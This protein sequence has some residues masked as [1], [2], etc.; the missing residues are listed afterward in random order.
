MFLRRHLEQAVPVLSE[1]LD[2]MRRP[3]IGQQQL[4]GFANSLCQDADLAGVLA[5]AFDVLGA[6]GRLEIRAGRSRKLVL[7]LFDGVYWDGGL[8][9]H[10]LAGY[11]SSKISLTDPAF[12]VTD[13]EIKEPEELLPLLD[14]A[15]GAGIATLC[16][17]PPAYPTRRYRSYCC[18]PIAST[19]RWCR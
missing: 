12:L 13:L 14:L 17:W 19:S 10:T 3:L 7:E 16:C 5:E 8:L 9:N 11:A 4:A 1:A 18:R 2:G 15:C 6:E